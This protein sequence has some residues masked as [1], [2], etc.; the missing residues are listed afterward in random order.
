MSRLLGRQEGVGDLASAVETAA[1]SYIIPGVPSDA[2]V[3]SQG[4]GDAE[5]DW[6]RAYQGLSRVMYQIKDLVVKAARAAEQKE[7]EDEQAMFNP[8]SAVIRSKYSLRE[9]LQIREFLV[10]YCCIPLLALSPGPFPAFQ[11]CTQLLGT[12][13]F[14]CH[15]L[16]SVNRLALSPDPFQLFK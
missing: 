11:F 12:R 8:T 9:M 1:S 7:L 4:G 15:T 5:V 2:S 10:I 3:G 13:L 14:L 6:K 16:M